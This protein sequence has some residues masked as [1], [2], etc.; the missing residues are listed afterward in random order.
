MFRV[1][2]DA[3]IFSIPERDV[4]NYFVWR[5]KDCLR[6]S[7][8]SKASA[9]FSPNQ[10]KNKKNTETIGMLE[11]LAKE[12]NDPTIQWQQEKQGNKNGFI[13]LSPIGKR[14]ALI[15]DAPIFLENRELIEKYLVPT[16]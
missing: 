3:R 5:Q 9:Y 14:D 10:I 12:Q 13:V 15:E 8:L 4:V 6:N 2:F 11:V 1:T 7:V 16:E